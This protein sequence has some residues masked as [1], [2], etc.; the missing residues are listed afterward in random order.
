MDGMP[1]WKFPS[2]PTARLVLFA[3]AS[4]TQGHVPELVAI[5]SNGGAEHG[6]NTLDKP[7]SRWF[8]VSH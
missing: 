5:P 6:G 3:A 8:T 4:S 1:A 7:E 2:T